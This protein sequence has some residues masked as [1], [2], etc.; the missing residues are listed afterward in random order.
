MLSKCEVYLNT[1]NF[2]DNGG[3]FNKNIYNY[4]LIW[5]IKKDEARSEDE[6]FYENEIQ[7]DAFE[8][9]K[10]KK[11]ENKDSGLL[12]FFIK[13]IITSVVVEAYFF[14]NDYLG[15]V[16]I[17]KITLLQPE[18]NYTISAKGFYLFAC[19]AQRRV[20]LDNQSTIMNMPNP[21]MAAKSIFLDV[22]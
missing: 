17:D 16:S 20:Y 2:V 11:F 13:I 7:D 5:N 8:T 9:K 14:V 21:L 18:F 1:L 6:Q 15:S 19:N 22:F 4:I 3:K 12:S 10:T